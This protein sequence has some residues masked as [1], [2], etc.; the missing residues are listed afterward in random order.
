MSDRISCL[1]PF[2]RRTRGQRKGEGPIREGEEWICGK[3]WSLIPKAYRRAHQ[4]L[5][6]Q[7]R[8]MELAW[9]KLPAGSPQR[10]ASIRMCQRLARLWRR[11]RQAAVE[12]AGGLR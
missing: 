11:L 12:R 2:C 10:T 7:A 9:W 8:R 5:C 4:R 3:H 6:R 1:V